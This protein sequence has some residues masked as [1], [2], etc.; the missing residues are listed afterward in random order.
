[1]DNEAVKNNINNKSKVALREEETIKF[2]QDNK[3]FEKSM[4]NGGKEFVFYDGPPF[5][6]GTPH[7]G[8]ILAGLIKDVIPRYKTMRGFF[9]PRRWGWDC[10]GL[11][12]ENLIEKE[13]GLA[14]KKD[15]EELGI[16]KFNN[17]AKNSVLRYAHIW[18]EMIPRFGRWV[19]MENDYRTMDT[20]YT[21]SVWWVF[22]TLYDKG[23]IYEG[24]KP[25]HLC[26]HCETT[27]SNFEVNQGYKDITDI[28]VYVTFPI[29]S[30]GKF[31]NKELIAWTTTPWTLPG[32]A[33]LA[34][35]PKIDYVEVEFENRTLILAKE[36]LLKLSEILKVELKPLKEFKGEEIVGL[37]Y[38]P[39]FNYYSSKA[40]LKNRE[41][42]W[43]VYGADFVTIEDGT[44]V[45][46]IAPA[47]GADDYE[48]SLKFKIPFLGHVNV[49]GTFKKEVSDFAGMKVKQ[50][51]ASGEKD[52]HQKG[53]IEVIKKL[54]SLGRLLAKEK[55][56]HSYPHCWRCETPL[57]NYATSSW[58]VEVTKIRDELVNVNK[59]I[60]WIPSEI[61]EGRFGKW[62]EGARDWSISRSRYWGAPLPVWRSE[63]GEIL[64]AGKFEDIRKKLKTKNEFYVI[65]HGESE[66]NVK[67]I[68]SSNFSDEYPLT[69]KG[70]EMVA[71]AI[72]KISDIYPSGFDIIYASPVLRTRQT[73]EM[74]ASAFNKERSSIIFDDRLAEINV[75]EFEDKNCSLYS[76]SFPDLMERFDRAPQGGENYTDVKNRVSKF[77]EEINS[78]NSGKKILIVTHE[79]V[80]WLLNSYALGLDKK[81]MIKR[82]EDVDGKETLMLPLAGIKKID[83]L[84]IPRNSFGEL[85]LHRPYIDEMEIFAEDG[86]KMK[87][88]PEV[89]DCWFESGSM[90]YGEAGYVGSALDN[91]NPKG[92][93]GIFGIGNKKSGFPADF[94]AEGQDQTRGW[95]YSMLVLGVGLFGE[96]PY[97]NV[98]VNGLI[99]AED[100]QK[101]S[102]SKKNYP[103]PIDVI[104]KFGMDAVRYYLLSSP[105][106]KA[107]EIRFSEKGVDEI[108]K[109]VIQRLENVISFYEMYVDSKGDSN[110]SFVE[111]SIALKSNNPLDK[112]IISKLEKCILDTTEALDGYLI[113]K[114]T[115]FTGD[116]IEEL[117]LWYL[118]RSRDRFKSDDVKDREMSIATTRYVLLELSKIIAPFIPFL[119]ESVYGRVKME[120]AP[121]SVHLLSWP[122]ANSDNIDSKL[123]SD[124]DKI[125]K[126]SSLGLEA[127]AK[128]GI[129]VRQPLSYMEADI[130]DIDQSLIDILKDEVNVKE[131]RNKADSKVE[132]NT[133]IS[134]ELLE[135]GV[136]RDLVRH[137][138]GMR[139]EAGL[140]PK[141][142][143]NISISGNKDLEKIVSVYKD[144]IKKTVG[145]REIIFASNMNNVEAKN[146]SSEKENPFLVQ[147]KKI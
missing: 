67:G 143:I 96:S 55:L 105:A 120:D 12:V 118:R 80:A 125:R 87:R 59:K 49:D 29:I 89:F 123:I 129:K 147:I 73:A 34:V 115:R 90:P 106:V 2:W 75:G 77:I 109:K 124:M 78:Q 94:I 1:M 131:I 104:N 114:A 146:N 72:K 42:G 15:I 100:G 40:D 136:F 81:E 64:V 36:R 130:T 54:A 4:Q 23:L 56:I 32:N 82:R 3:V 58:F 19:D 85:D 48:L 47:F 101:M 26:P 92:S 142:E 86:S 97:K 121:M 108:L 135:E 53:D 122:I 144:E 134:S 18:R 116:F 145:A 25:M 69:L 31:L 110:L 24:F 33:A 27:L 21:E 117:S 70:R 71:G 9:V 10:H 37:S 44:G 22:K 127:R 46:H 68:H 140:I 98:I 35:N 38:E 112:W 7:Y 30:E 50:K 28:S 84:P 62:L 66:T 57:L 14:T 113:D 83:I 17:S 45:V 39:I 20:S 91:F 139:K 74:I 11:P 16:E 51:N 76:E 52:A 137:I 88:V 6:T 103:D 126:L 8:H 63:S 132:L 60:N 5:A 65:R 41:N 79:C 133:E 119:A 102:K 99:L 61:G 95:F 43:K 138:Q 141:D 13:L 93:S 128:A 111:P 107:E